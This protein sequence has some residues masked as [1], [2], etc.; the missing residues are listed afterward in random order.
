MKI[1]LTNDDGVGAPGI[2]LLTA[3]AKTVGEVTVAAPDGVPVAAARD[4]RRVQRLLQAPRR[5][6]IPPPAVRRRHKRRRK[7]HSTADLFSLPFVQNDLCCI[8]SNRHCPF[9]QHLFYNSSNK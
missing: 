7:N 8:L 5:R 9:R 4:R 6:V 3:F 1:L 2:A